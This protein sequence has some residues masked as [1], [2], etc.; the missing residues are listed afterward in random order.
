MVGPVQS[1]LPA[2]TPSVTETTAAPAPDSAAGP[3][4]IGP[5]DRIDVRV[6]G[7]EPLSGTF[8]VNENGLFSLPLLGSVLARGH[9]PTSLERFLE[10][11]LREKYMRDPHVTVQVVE[12]RSRSVSIVGAVRRPGVYPLANPRSLLEVLAMAEGLSEQAGEVAL[13]VRGGEVPHAASADSGAAYPA[14]A[15][16][17]V[18]LGALLQNGDTEQNVL[19]HPGDVLQI[20]P[21]GIVYVVGEVVQPGGFTLSGGRPLTVLQALALARGLGPTASAGNTVI[22]RT[23]PDGSRQE[24]PVDLDKVLDGSLVPPLLSAED[25][26]FVPNNEAKSVALGV[27]NALVRMVTLRGLVY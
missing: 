13:V 2:P 9:T 11:R 22:V 8:T 16:L 19:V 4:T 17:E 6:F 27:V 25:V 26:L 5:D 15:L 10:E 18:D 14:G 1:A 7:A 12:M 23:A 3:Y 21:A 24:V 20:R